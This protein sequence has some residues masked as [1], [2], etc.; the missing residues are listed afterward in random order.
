MIKENEYEDIKVLLKEQ[1][2]LAHVRSADGRGPMFWAHEHGR[3]K[4]VQLLKEERVSESR[5]D[6]NGRTPLHT[7][8]LK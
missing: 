5:T 4:I 3:D 2:F 8:K 6:A 7:S 1:P